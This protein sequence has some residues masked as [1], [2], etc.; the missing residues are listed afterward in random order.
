MMMCPRPGGYIASIT[1][2]SSMNVSLSCAREANPNGLPRRTSNAPIQQSVPWRLY[3]NSRLTG[4]R[5]VIA[6][7]AYFRSSAWMP[8]FSSTHTMCSFFG[9]S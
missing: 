9:V 4:C 7:S 5:G 1:S 3:S 2:S 6:M 8:V